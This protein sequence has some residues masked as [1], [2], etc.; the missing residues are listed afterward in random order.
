[1]I[2]KKTA[3]KLAYKSENIVYNT[4]RDI[5]TLIEIHAKLG[6]FHIEVFTTKKFAEGCRERLQSKGFNV[7]IG[8]IESTPNQCLLYVSW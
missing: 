7:T 4:I 1:M 2:S 5:S 8:D 6:H 3:Q